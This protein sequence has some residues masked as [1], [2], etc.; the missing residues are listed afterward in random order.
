MI[1]GNS[2]L[3]ISLLTTQLPSLVNFN[4]NGVPSVPVGYGR[5]TA[6]VL[7]FTPLDNGLFGSVELAA[8][9]HGVPATIGFDV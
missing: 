4:S 1:S 8:G 7:G 3:Y 9:D 5:S 2:I 6:P